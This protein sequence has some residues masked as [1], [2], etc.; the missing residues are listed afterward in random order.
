MSFEAIQKELS[1]NYDD[2]SSWILER[3]SNGTILFCKSNRHNGQLYAMAL[4]PEFD[5]DGK[6][7]DKHLLAFLNNIQ[8]KRTQPKYD[9]MTFQEYG[10]IPY[11]IEEV[12]KDM[13]AEVVGEGYDD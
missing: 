4:L 8:K 2:D 13:E 10:G 5:R 12:M 6:T 3:L 11:V 9:D 1:E 7:D